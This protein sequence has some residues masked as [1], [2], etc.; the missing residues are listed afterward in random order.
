MSTFTNDRGNSV[1][2]LGHHEGDR[3]DF[4]FGVCSPKSGWIQYD[5]DQDASYFGVWVHI[6][7][8]QV[9]TFCEGDTSLVRCENLETFKSELDSLAKF[10]GEAPPAFRTISIDGELTEHYC[11]RPTV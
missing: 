4:D 6:D 3:Y 11:N 9:F 1:E 10:H 2:D 7:R 8:R 5:T